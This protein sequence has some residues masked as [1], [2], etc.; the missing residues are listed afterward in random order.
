MRQ[1]EKIVNDIVN[2]GSYEELWTSICIMANEVAHLSSKD[3]TSIKLNPQILSLGFENLI[4]NKF[5]LDTIRLI[6]KKYQDQLHEDDETSNAKSFEQKKIIIQASQEECKIALRFMWLPFF[7]PSAILGSLSTS[8]SKNL[9]SDYNFFLKKL[10]KEAGVKIEFIEFINIIDE[11]FNMKRTKEKFTAYI[12]CTNFFNLQIRASILN[13]FLT[14]S[15]KKIRQISIIFKDL[16]EQRKRGENFNIPYSLCKI[17]G[18]IDYFETEESKLFY[19]WKNKFDNDELDNFNT[20]T[21]SNNEKLLPFFLK[22]ICSG[23][24]F[25]K[26]EDEKKGHFG[27]NILN[28]IE[29]S[30][31]LKNQMWEFATLHL[32]AFY[33]EKNNHKEWINKIYLTSFVTLA[34]MEAIKKAKDNEWQIKVVVKALSDWI[35]EISSILCHLEIMDDYFNIKELMQEEN[36]QIEWKSTFMTPTEISETHPNKDI[37]KEIV[38]NILGMANSSGGIIIVGAVEHP[39]KIMNQTVKNN[40]YFRDKNCFFDVDYEL[41]NILHKSTDEIERMIQDYLHNETDRDINYL[42]K[43]WHME[44]L[45]INCDGTNLSIFQIKVEK[46]DEKL[47]SRENIRGKKSISLCIRARRRI[48]YVDPSDHIE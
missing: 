20:R 3:V 48:E 45:K 4:Q 10:I 31:D 2:I 5:F 38:K 29:F 34:K 44:E 39:E 16:T 23:F 17:Y 18:V 7:L 33:N 42:D 26:G 27:K 14:L 41:K 30:S 9:R 40:L 1:L 11:I 24:N 12:D 46:S 21:K 19:G 43:L 36:D 28:K 37:L 35:N 15:I 6:I 25:K 8:L 32:S 47:F 22:P 13:K